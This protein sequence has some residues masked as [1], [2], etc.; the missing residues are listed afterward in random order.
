MDPEVGISMILC[1]LGYELE[2][3]S[4]GQIS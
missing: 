1:L 4:K 3:D 2:M